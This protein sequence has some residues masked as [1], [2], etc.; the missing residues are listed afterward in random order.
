[1]NGVYQSLPNVMCENI[2]KE[3]SPDRLKEYGSAIRELIT[4]EDELTNMRLTWLNTIQGL[5]FAAFALASDY[6]SDNVPKAKA[7]AY[8]LGAVGILTALNTKWMIKQ[9]EIA[10]E[11][12]LVKWKDYVENYCKIYPEWGTFEPVIG[13]KPGTEEENPK[14]WN[15]E[16]YQCKTLL[17]TL[18]LP[19]HQDAFIASWVVII[20][21][22]VCY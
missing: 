10:T 17:E 14:Y 16:G 3:Y 6:E 1:M 22:V 20:F 12:L 7:L 8:V 4:K 19:G 9:G 21:I 2:K 5:L 15:L 18:C 13:L 11:G